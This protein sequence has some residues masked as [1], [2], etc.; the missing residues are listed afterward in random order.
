MEISSF[1]GG[2]QNGV[3]IRGLP[4]Q[5]AHPGETFY[6]N[7]SSSLAKN[8]IGGSDVNNGTYR[9]PFAT[10]DHAISKCTASRGDIVMVMPGHQETITTAGE[11]DL[12]VAGVA[13]I[14]LGTHNLRPKIIEVGTLSHV[15]MTAANCTL[16]NIVFESGSSDAFRAVEASAVG[17]TLGHLSFQ[18]QSTTLNFR[19]FIGATSLVA[20]TGD[21]LYISHCTGY[22]TSLT[23]LEPIQINKDLQD[24]VVEHCHFNMDGTTALAM[25]RVAAGESLTNCRITNNHYES[26]QTTG[27][28][29][30]D[31]DTTTNDG[32]IAYNTSFHNDP[33]GEVNIDCTGAGLFENYA[34]GAVDV[35][36]YLTPAADS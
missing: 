31:S 10:I 4:L 28:I 21:G 7:N 1:T 34:S 32:V 11:I 2:P 13:I 22:G 29:L 33:V 12:N 27:D 30:V 25:V 20:N 14:G 8:G 3:L 36:G 26:L 19:T 6:V 23:V 18:D 5:A 17:C 24:L 9:K 35:Q 16:Y 15:T